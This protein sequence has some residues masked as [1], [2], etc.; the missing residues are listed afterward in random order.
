MEMSPDEEIEESIES[1]NHDEDV[2]EDEGREEL[3]E[4]DEI[5]AAEEGFMQGYESDEDETIEGEE[6]E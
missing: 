6:K 5:D 2:Y 4:D 3:V 1:E